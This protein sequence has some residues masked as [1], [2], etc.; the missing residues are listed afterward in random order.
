MK[1]V[2]PLALTATLAACGYGWEKDSSSNAYPP[3]EGSNSSVVA[4]QAAPVAGAGEYI[5][6]PGDTLYAI[7]FRNQLDYHEL[8]DWN[9][10]GRD[11]LIRP[12]QLLRLTPP[13]G[14][15]GVL[16]K[17]LH[18]PAPIIAQPTA[19]PSPS[20]VVI[21][22]TAP[23]QPGPVT[24]APV[25]VMPTV[26][27]LSVP[28]IPRPMPQG[29]A[30][31]RWQWPTTGTV[32]K[33]YNMAA[34]S[35]GIDI[36]GELGQPVNAVASGKVVYSGSALKGYGELIIIKHDDTYLSAYGH[37][38]RRLVKEGDEVRTGQTV[39]EL[40][41]GPEQKPTLHFEIRENGKPVDPLVFL[42]RQ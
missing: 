24:Q 11:Y 41:V 20:P 36:S 32:I 5:V 42:P 19:I 8:A 26:P 28:P 16:A 6:Q 29:N 1:H 21:P 12:G 3:S 10:I 18:T 38:R 4:G 37:N 22:P 17:P 7:S 14:T 27:V 13:V 23:P 30:A 9:G 34:G 39:A 35:K 25:V 2:I 33:T 15:D 40:G 31:M